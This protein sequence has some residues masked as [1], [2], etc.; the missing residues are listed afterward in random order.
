MQQTGTIK[1]I[2]K[3]I[4]FSKFLVCLMSLDLQLLKTDFANAFLIK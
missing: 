4:F 1:K 3:T 2:F